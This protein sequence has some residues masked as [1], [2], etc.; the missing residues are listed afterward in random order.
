MLDMEREAAASFDPAPTDGLSTIRLAGELNG[1]VRL[2]PVGGH[3][4]DAGAAGQPGSAVRVPFNDVGGIDQTRDRRAQVTNSSRRAGNPRVADDA[5]VEAGPVDVRVIPCGR[6]RELPVPGAAPAAA[7]R[8]D[9]AP[10]AFEHV[11]R[12]I[13]GT[14]G[15]YS[16]QGDCMATRADFTNDNGC[17]SARRNGQ[18]HARFAERPGLHGLVREASAMAKDLN[19]QQLAAPNDLLREI[20]KTHG[21][22]FGLTTSPDEFRNETMDALRVGLAA[23]KAKSPADLD[24]YKALVIGLAQ[25]V[26]DAKGGGTSQLEMAMIVE[27]KAALATGDAPAQTD[28]LA[29]PETPA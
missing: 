5:Q 26:A 24:G 21:T 9:Q 10:E 4:R 20:A 12:Q 28:L 11:T 15:D 3:N 1:I 2:D 23:L 13:L 29:Q 14:F 19:G 6:R 16:A 17:A 27:I 8:P 25:A 18:R 22:G 7:G